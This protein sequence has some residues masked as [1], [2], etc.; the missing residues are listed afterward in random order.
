MGGNIVLNFIRTA[1]VGVLCV[2]VW[3]AIAQYNS[4]E[5]RIIE[6][7]GAVEDASERTRKNTQ[8]LEEMQRLLKSGVAV[9]G[10]TN[11]AIETSTDDPRELAYW[12]TDDNILVDPAGEPAPPTSAPRGGTLNFYV[13]SNLDKLNIHVKNDADL[14]DKVS[15]FVYQKIGDQSR[16]NPDNYVGEMANRVTISEDKRVFT[17]YVRKGCFW[18]EPA[19]T[20]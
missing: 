5:T 6:V 11:G 18:H 19:L 9:R 13:A 20:A 7:K 1:I 4:F 10:G 16:A 14:Q 8:L 2:L 17:V 15:S 12:P 3:M